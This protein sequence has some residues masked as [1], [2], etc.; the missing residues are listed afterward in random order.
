VGFIGW[1]T[2]DEYLASYRAD[3]DRMAA[4]LRVADP[5]A[6]VPTC[7]GWTALDLLRHVC[8]VY[9]HKVAVLRLGRAVRPGEWTL[10]DELDQANALEWHDSIR[11]ELEQL[12]AELGPDAAV[13]TWMEGVGEGTSGA[14]ARR[15]AH[16][17]LV[18]RVDAESVQGSP[19]AE[20]A[21]G[22]AVDGINEILT[23]MAGDP[24]VLTS[25]GAD[26]GA[27]GSV[28]VDFGDGAWLVGLPDGAQSV[29]LVGSGSAATARMSGSALGLDLALWG[30]PAEVEESGDEG[31]LA[32]LRARSGSPRS[33]RGRRTAT[34][35][36]RADAGATGGRGRRAP[37]WRA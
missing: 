19:L 35:P 2:H 7:P 28:L 9:A 30:R 33:S 6:P 18:H 27:A 8:D 24:D 10:A 3:G 31:V 5:G 25:D 1:L 26:E 36:T 29:S 15:M 14:W 20:A 37:G 12:L 22:L 17:A 23:W 4:L 34:R 21:P 16:E 32:R 11:G 13:W